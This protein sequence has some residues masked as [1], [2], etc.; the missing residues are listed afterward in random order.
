MLSKNIRQRPFSPPKAA[1]TTR[2][3]L[4]RHSSELSSISQVDGAL[5]TDSVTFFCES[6]DVMWF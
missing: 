5:G 6:K 1:E 4:M 2:P 3:V